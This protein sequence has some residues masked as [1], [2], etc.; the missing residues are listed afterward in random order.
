M[1]ELTDQYY[2]PGTGEVQ[3]KTTPKVFEWN[4]AHIEQFK[5]DILRAM[6]DELC[7]HY[8]GIQIYEKSEEGIDAFKSLFPFQMYY[9]K[10]YTKLYMYYRIPDEVTTEVDRYCNLYQIF[11]NR[12][13]QIAKQDYGWELRVVS[14]DSYAES[15]KKKNRYVEVFQN[16]VPIY[17]T[18]LWFNKV[19]YDRYE[20]IQDKIMF[21]ILT[22]DTLLNK[23]ELQR[24]EIMDNYVAGVVD[25]NNNFHLT[26]AQSTAKSAYNAYKSLMNDI[27]GITLPDTAIN[28]CER[29]DYEIEMLGK[30]AEERKAMNDG[31]L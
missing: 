3:Y 26:G 20:F 25:I 21:K 15:V 30:N 8:K 6:K 10:D 1:I 2:N 22:Q 23:T 17:T 11:N 4:K 13:Y 24:K 12:F 9:L 27:F 31:I 28:K 29:W 7:E 14:K 19:Y 5:K 18:G 16:K